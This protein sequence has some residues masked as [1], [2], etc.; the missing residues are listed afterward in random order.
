MARISFTWRTAQG[1]YLDPI[2]PLR[3]TSARAPTA[4]M[5]VIHKYWLAK[6]LDGLD[7]DVVGLIVNQIFDFICKRTIRLPALE[8]FQ[9]LRYIDTE[10]GLSYTCHPNV[11]G[12][13]LSTM[14]MI[15][16]YQDDTTCDIEYRMRDYTVTVDALC[17]S[18]Y[19][20]FRMS[21]KPVNC[22]RCYEFYAVTTTI[23]WFWAVE[24]HTKPF[25]IDN[26]HRLSLCNTQE[27]QWSCITYKQQ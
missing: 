12:R 8:E 17:K 2:L 9:G 22:H 20:C 4:P 21:N 10:T 18:N 13:P 16:F 26:Q 27:S 1:D 19:G 3:L 6:Q 15:Q 24:G 7:I 23:D 25:L 5:D 14:L 11:T